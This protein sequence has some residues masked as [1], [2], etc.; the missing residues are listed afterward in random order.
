MM[1]LYV[2][3]LF[4]MASMATGLFFLFKWLMKGDENGTQ[5]KIT[6]K[7]TPSRKGSSGSTN[8]T[9]KRGST[10]EIS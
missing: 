4:V 6:P 5:E 9:S 2:A 1:F 3:V 7:E 10:S 8:G